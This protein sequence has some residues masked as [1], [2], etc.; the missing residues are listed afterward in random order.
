MNKTNQNF[1]RKMCFIH[2]R[3]I[4]LYTFRNFP[5]NSSPRKL[6]NMLRS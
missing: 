2:N 5:F 6:S 1:V 3:F 4:F